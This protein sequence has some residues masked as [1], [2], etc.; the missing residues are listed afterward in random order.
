MKILVLGDV[1]GRAGRR[2]VKNRLDS[3]KSMTKSD[4]VIINGE[5]LAGGFG[6]TRATIDEMFEAGVDV[7]TTG[8][9]VWDK[10]EALTLVES[11][12]RLLR[13]AN[14]PARTP[15][16]GVARYEFGSRSVAVLNLMGQ[17]FMTSLDCPFRRADEEVDKLRADGIKIILVDIH[18]EATSE[19]EAIA[20]HLNGRVS[21]VWGTHTHVATADERILN[22]GSAYI[23][24]VGMTGP[25]DSIIGVKPEIILKRFL[26]KLPERFEE[27]AGPAKLNAITLEID[28]STGL[29]RSIK[30]I[31]LEETFS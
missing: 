3:L 23:S 25:R 14:Y 21:A 29:A 9:H 28:D 1:F 18:A 30:R 26:Y 11:E 17:V 15:G 7:I 6:L 13:P 16:R 31:S 20:L 10:K 27:A 4:L 12:K 19:K 22:R 24:D 2:V 5:N 8:N